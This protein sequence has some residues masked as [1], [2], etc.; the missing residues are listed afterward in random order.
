[1]GVTAVAIAGGKLKGNQCDSAGAIGSNGRARCTL[2]SPQACPG[3]S[4]ECRLSA[5]VLAPEQPPAAPA[6]HE[7]V[8]APAER[9]GA[10]GGHR[11]APPNIGP[12]PRL[13]ARG[14]AV[15]GRPRP[16]PRPRGAP[17]GR[18]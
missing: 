10:I 12:R 17:R 3:K 6:E 4:G 18:G 16:P 2:F 7:R 9:Q 1:G 11:R 15:R 13:A 5:P 14:A 8:E